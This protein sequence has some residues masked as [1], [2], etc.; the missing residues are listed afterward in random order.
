MISAKDGAVF[1][2]GASREA[3]CELVLMPTL[4]T[5]TRIAPT[6][7]RLQAISRIIVICPSSVHYAINALQAE[8]MVIKRSSGHAHL[9]GT[10]RAKRQDS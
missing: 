2:A 4:P 7:I 8:M 1:S 10:M 9:S 6:L 5:I 3:V